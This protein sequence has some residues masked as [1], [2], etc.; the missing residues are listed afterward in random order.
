MSWFHITL[1]LH[2]HF[3][4]CPSFLQDRISTVNPFVQTVTWVQSPGRTMPASVSVLQ[5][6]IC[7]FHATNGTFIFLGG[8]WPDGSMNC[9][10]KVRMNPTTRK[11]CQC[12]YTI[13]LCDIYLLCNDKLKII[14]PII[15]VFF[16]SWGAKSSWDRERVITRNNINNDATLFACVYMRNC[17]FNCPCVY[18]WTSEKN[19]ECVCTRE[20][21]LR[22]SVLLLF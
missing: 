19:R 5:W 12:F 6:W 14:R 13:T 16:S 21:G 4:L 3:I 20:R 11:W 7:F 18:L 15:V 22:G 10:R 1:L 8:I 2:L 17:I 9:I